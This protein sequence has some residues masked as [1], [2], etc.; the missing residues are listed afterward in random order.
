MIPLVPN[1]QSLIPA[2]FPTDLQRYGPQAAP[3]EPLT[4]RQSRRYCRRLAQRH[5][6]NF[7]VASLL[8][9]RRLRQHVCNI[10]AYC[11]WADDLADEVADPQQSLALLDWW[12]SQLHNCYDGPTTHPVFVALAETIR[13]F[14]IPREPFTDL[15]SAF[16]QDQRVTRYESTDQLL[17]YCRRSAN[18]VGR[19]VLCL[20]RCH[21]PELVRLSDSICTGLQL[22]NFCQDVAGDWDRGRIYLPQTACRQF[23][24]SEADFARRECNDAFRR[25][26]ADQVNQAESWLRGGLPLAAQM[27]SGMRLPVALFAHG[28]LA[29]LAAIRRQNYDVWTRRPTVSRYEKLRLMLGCWWRLQFG[30]YTPI[31]PV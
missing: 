22:A 17:E 11:R 31:E 5:Y 3:S 24:Y 7:T 21:T 25:L 26:L 19:L 16:R 28:G 14:D 18:P 6:E 10:Y 15:L 20:G 12:E 2:M 27:P 13:Q 4:P 8:L 29:I 30:D 1:S 23:G 9:P